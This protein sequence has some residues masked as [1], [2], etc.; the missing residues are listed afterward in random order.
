MQSDEPTSSEATRRPGPPR[1]LVVD[2]DPAIRLVCST[3]L[4]HD[5][6]QVLVAANGQEGLELA[7]DQVPDVVLLE[8]SMPVLD[9]FG[10]AAALQADE[11]TRE[12]PLIFLTSED[13]PL[14]KAKAFETGAHGV[15]AKP[16]EPSA[17]TSLIGRVVAQVVPPRRLSVDPQR[18]A[19]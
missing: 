5:G 16:F 11:R 17:V 7:L 13:D 19:L 8:I 18:Q 9:G 14:I 1:V 2:D 12:L 10:L 3:N 4:Q 6:Y 15:I